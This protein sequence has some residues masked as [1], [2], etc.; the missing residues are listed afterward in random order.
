MHRFREGI[1]IDYHRPIT[2]SNKTIDL[3]I[4]P[5]TC[6]GDD[7][8]RFRIETKIASNG[9]IVLPDFWNKWTCGLKFNHHT[10]QQL[11]ARESVVETRSATTV[12]TMQM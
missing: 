5:E 4:M 10:N 9:A 3:H 2:I 8:C 6:R 1:D 7:E 12:S 11:D